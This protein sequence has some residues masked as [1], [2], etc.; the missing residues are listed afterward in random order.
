MAAVARRNERDRSR[1]AASVRRDCEEGLPITL[2][3]VMRL[4]NN[5]LWGVKVIVPI[6]SRLRHGAGMPE[7]IDPAAVDPAS[8]LAPAGPA[9]DPDRAFAASVALF[10]TWLLEV[11]TAYVR[12]GVLSWRGDLPFVGAVLSSEDGGFDWSAVRLNRATADG[13][14]VLAHI[15]RACERE[16]VRGILKAIG[17]ASDETLG[18]ARAH[19]NELWPDVGGRVR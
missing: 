12:S 11:D 1:L 7:S 5:G 9:S 17:V 2:L 15:A 14:V 6:G 16:K 8:A 18:R 13:A 4:R 19:S 10:C 3:R